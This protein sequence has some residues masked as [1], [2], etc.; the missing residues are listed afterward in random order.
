MSS[1]KILITGAS[2]GIGKDAALQLSRR[3]G[4][5]LAL[6]GRNQAR[7]EE[8]AAA[9]EGTPAVFVGDLTKP[10]LAEEITAQAEEA[11]GGLDGLIHCAGEGLIRPLKD[12]TDA[13]FSRLLNTNLRVA[14][15]CVQAAAHR[16]ASHKKGRILALP[17]VLGKFPMKATAAYSASKFGLSGLL[18][19]VAT[20]YQRQGVQV[21]QVY[22]GGV[23]SPFWDELDM[24]VQRD[25][26]IPSAVI[27]EHIASAMTA[28]AHLVTTEL[29][30][31]PDSH[32]FL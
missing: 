15:L 19:V 27:A 29:V 26:M 7:L 25:K 20:E 17:G 18:K 23:D 13:E 6:T 30:I 11:M 1:Q 9:C 32:L 21:I 14:F 22:S 31:Q 16:M 3:P 8:T 5:Q 28:P 2:S 4:L 24:K 10:G 12:T